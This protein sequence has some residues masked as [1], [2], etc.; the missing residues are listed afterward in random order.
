MN[1]QAP[2]KPSSVHDLQ[3]VAKYDASSTAANMP[4]QQRGRKLSSITKRSE[5]QR[6]R[7]QR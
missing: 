4:K 1:A 3:D 2:A 5:E 7:D 6:R